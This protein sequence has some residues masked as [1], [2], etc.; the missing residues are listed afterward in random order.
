MSKML[1]S[2]AVLMI[3]A[4]VAF[5]PTAAIAAPHSNPVATGTH[6]GFLQVLMQ[7]L[8]FGSSAPV[9]GGTTVSPRS[10]GGTVSADTATWGGGGRCGLGGC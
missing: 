9:Q 4:V 1:K 2:A 3:L 10:T 5:G 7:F 6:F 8:G